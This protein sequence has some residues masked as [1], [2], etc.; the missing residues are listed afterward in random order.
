MVKAGG[1]LRRSVL[2]GSLSPDEVLSSEAGKDSTFLDVEPKIGFSVRNFHIQAAKMARVSDIVVY[3]SHGNSDTKVQTLAKRIANAQ[4][5]WAAQSA[6][7][8]REVPKF[9]T[10]VVTSECEIARVKSFLPI[11]ASDC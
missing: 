2:K 11:G 3:G 9:H 4:R 10:F 7:R 8:Q 5:E 6:M 1:D